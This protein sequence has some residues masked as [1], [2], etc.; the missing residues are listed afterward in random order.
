M[1]PF[2]VL[3]GPT[4]GGKSA[5]ALALS[6]QLRHLGHP[7][8]IISADAFQVYR[9]MDIGTAKPSPADRAAVPHHLI[10][11]RDPCETFTLDDWR[12]DAESCIHSMR[13][14]GA[15]PIVVGGTHLYIKT[16]LEGLFDGPPPDEFL[17]ESLKSSPPE[18][19][20]A[21]LQSVDPRAAERIHVNDIRRTIR[22][23]EIFRQ[24][25]RPISDLQRQ[26]DQGRRDD[27]ILVALAWPPESI[28]P[29]INERV[30]R[31]IDDGLVDEAHTLW[32]GDLLGPQSREAIGY[33]QL[34]DY[35][36]GR[37][38]L[39]DAIEQIKI[40]TRR[41]AKNQRTWIRR[42]LVTPPKSRES[43]SINAKGYPP[44]EIAQLIAE[45]I[46]AAD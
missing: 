3:A 8:E 11:I 44:D 9:G 43:V 38:T 2:P 14:R 1:L 37:S 7:S 10:D 13:G 15:L 6:E 46:I 27:A 40:S 45:A 28:N 30:R 17:R 20:R 26:W 41:L 19:L 16:L 29:R 42:L 21:E 34:I 36:E 31:M 24:T 23:I 33:L 35:F 4:A 12:R 22:A 39:A 25:G 5:V 32:A 18:L